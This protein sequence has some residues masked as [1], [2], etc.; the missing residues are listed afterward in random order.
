MHP[1]I[2][3]NRHDHSRTVCYNIDIVSTFIR[4]TIL[5]SLYNLS[6]LARAYI[7][8]HEGSL[9]RGQSYQKRGK[10]VSEHRFFL[11]FFHRSFIFRQC[12]FDMCCSLNYS[13]LAA[14]EAIQKVVEQ[15]RLLGDPVGNANQAN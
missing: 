13:L 8:K 14:T 3:Y 1:Y 12:I 9:S 6:S 10:Q 5:F 11:S 2:S 7:E 4:G 15:F